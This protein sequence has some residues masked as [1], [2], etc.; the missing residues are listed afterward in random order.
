[1]SWSRFITVENLC[2]AAEVTA[3]LLLIAFA[4]PEKRGKSKSIV[5]SG[6]QKRLLDLARRAFLE[7]KTVIALGQLSGVYSSIDG[8]PATMRPCNETDDAEQL[9][10]IDRLSGTFN[11]SFIEAFLN[12]WLALPNECRSGS[13]LTMVS[14]QEYSDLVREIGP[15][16]VELLLRDLACKI[17]SH[18]GDCSIIARLPPDRF[19][20]A[21]FNSIPMSPEFGL[22]LLSESASESDN[23]TPTQPPLPKLVTSIVELSD[24]LPSVEETL[25]TLDE[26]TD[27]AIRSN[28]PIAFKRGPH[29]TQEIPTNVARSSNSGPRSK[30]ND[31]ES[32]TSNTTEKN[33]TE[34]NTSQAIENGASTSGTSNLDPSDNDSLPES[35]KNSKTSSVDKTTPNDSA[36]AET[37]NNSKSA[38]VSAVASN[39]ELAA[40][41]AQIKKNDSNSTS[42]AKKSTT[43]VD[44]VP[45]PVSDKTESDSVS[46]DD[47]ASLFA[48]AK[49]SVKPTVAK[50]PVSE[51]DSDD[52]SIPNGNATAESVAS[53][54]DDET[55]SADDIASLFAAN[56]PKA[57][58]NNPAQTQSKSPSNQENT[59][60]EGKAGTQSRSRETEELEAMSETAKADDISEL[61]KAVQKENKPAGSNSSK[62]PVVAK[63]PAIQ[64][65]EDLSE[66][67]TNDDIAELFKAVQS[68]LGGAKKPPAPPQEAP[69]PAEP[70]DLSAEASADDIAALFAQIKGKS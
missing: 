67:A 33:T 35:E 6:E 13:F 7:E 56:K 18:V 42:S 66:T 62:K 70:E 48:A 38:D 26:G 9:G 23:D 5:D 54:S 8:P 12:R 40:L 22:I 30:L 53:M 2:I 43:S 61:F 65:I 37:A 46:A 69:K 36:N 3:A 50:E 28:E 51:V 47:I 21:T 29:W 45:D 24:E 44:P 31:A 1:M 34:K 64:E 16:K 52:R 59:Q 32:R 10:W 20:I 57:A 17:Q 41:F 55:V 4:I 14:L 63:N 15:V 49:S 11:K 58:P 19:L 68:G 27:S 25:N 60:K 39:E